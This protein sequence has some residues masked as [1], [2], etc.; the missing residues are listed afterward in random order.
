MIPFTLLRQ[1]NT[2][3]DVLSDCRKNDLMQTLRRYHWSLRT[4]F[5]AGAETIQ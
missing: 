3:L 1:N 2:F 4:Q 5:S